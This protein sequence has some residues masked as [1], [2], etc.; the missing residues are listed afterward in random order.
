ML[1][2]HFGN[3]N[4]EINC[5]KNKNKEVIDVEKNI[6]MANPIKKP[7]QKPES[8]K[9]VN[10]SKILKVFFL[11]LIL[12]QTIIL[13][14]LVSSELLTED[15]DDVSANYSHLNR[16]VF[17]SCA[18]TPCKP[19]PLTNPIATR[20]VP[21]YFNPHVNQSPSI[22]P[23]QNNHI[24]PSA[25]FSS[26]YYPAFMQSMI[27]ANSHSSPA[28]LSK[29]EEP[30]QLDKISRMATNQASPKSQVPLIQNTN[31]LTQRVTPNRHATNPSVVAQNIP[32]T[33]R[34]PPF[35]PILLIPGNEY[36]PG[37]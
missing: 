18:T 33:D 11:V 31:I 30:H 1:P 5:K 13:K 26:Y 24:Q 28:S 12:I 19:S 37:Q 4:G 6:G 15:E 3:H 20:Y 23:L 29:R 35:S 25:P 32:Q 27:E 14:E 34:S 36:T 17:Y 2:L 8:F 22:Q 9:N 7:N 16:G 10:V 21:N